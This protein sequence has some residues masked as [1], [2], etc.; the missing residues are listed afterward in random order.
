VE[1]AGIED[2]KA[3]VLETYLGTASGRGTCILWTTSDTSA[4]LGFSNLSQYHRLLNSDSLL[5]RKLHHAKPVQMFGVT[6][7]SAQGR[8]LERL[9]TVNLMLVGDAAGFNSMV[10]ACVTGRCA[11]EVAASAVTTGDTSEKN[12]SRYADIIREQGLYRTTLSWT[13]GMASL[14]SRSDREIEAMI[15]ELLARGEVKY[16]DIWDF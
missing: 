8:P 3:G 9:V 1:F 2:I 7:G 10:H 12:L 16:R 6:S 13:E 15:P 11:G 5:A 14:R 4:L